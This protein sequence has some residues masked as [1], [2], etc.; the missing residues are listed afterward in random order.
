MDTFMSQ[1]QAEIPRHLR[2]QVENEKKHR[3]A[4]KYIISLLMIKVIYYTRLTSPKR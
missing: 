2:N 3:P 1:A 4:L